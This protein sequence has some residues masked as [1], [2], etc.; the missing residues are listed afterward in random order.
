MAAG[1][2]FGMQSA[3]EKFAREHID[4]RMSD[5]NQKLS[6]I[7]H[8]LEKIM[9]KIS[10]FATAMTAFTDRQD[11]AVSDLQDDVKSLND[12]IT[13]LQ[14]SAGDITPEDQAALD[15]IQAR[16]GAVA[17]KLDALDALT[18]PVVPTTP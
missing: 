1:W 15:A 7:S 13:E 12:K 3:F 6:G 17:D 8:R 11:K 18:P 9:S 14:N 10:D 5:V 4:G 16:A 2:L